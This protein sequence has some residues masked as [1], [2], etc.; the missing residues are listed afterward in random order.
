MFYGSD[1]VIGTCV[2][3][4]HVNSFLSSCPDPF[5]VHVILSMLKPHPLAFLIQRRG[6]ERFILR[7]TYF[8]LLFKKQIYFQNVQCLKGIGDV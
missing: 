6:E 4:I 2:I 3:Y 7:Q 5:S 1:H 8:M